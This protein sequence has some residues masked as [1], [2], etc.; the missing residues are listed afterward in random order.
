VAAAAAGP[1]EFPE[2][3]PAEAAQWK[4]GQTARIQADREAEAERMARLTPVTDAEIARYGTGQ[5]GAEV[6]PERAADE[7]NIAEISA[8][9]ERVGELIDR[10]PDR[11]AEQRAQREQEAAAEPGIRPQAEPGLE[12]SWQPGEAGGHS[13][14]EADME[15]EAE[16]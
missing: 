7:A 13:D 9:L 16:I 14:A 3:D 4:A 5:P 11:Q 1:R 8:E 10:I 12:P 2:I 15:A 6:S